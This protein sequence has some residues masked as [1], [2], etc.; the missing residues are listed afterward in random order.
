MDAHPARQG[1]AD[2]ALTLISALMCRAK[3]RYPLLSGSAPMK[4]RS[5]TVTLPANPMPRLCRPAAPAPYS[6]SARLPPR[7]SNA[8]CSVMPPLKPQRC[9]SGAGK[10]CATATRPAGPSTASSRWL[11]P[12]RRAQLPA[13]EP[14]GCLWHKHAAGCVNRWARARGPGSR[15]RCLLSSTNLRHAAFRRLKWPAERSRPARGRSRSLRLRPAMAVPVHVVVEV[16]VVD[17]VLA[18]QHEHVRAALLQAPATLLFLILSRGASRGCRHLSAPPQETRRAGAA[19]KAKGQVQALRTS[20]ASSAGRTP[21]A[22][23][24]PPAPCSCR[25]SRS[26]CSMLPSSSS[27]FPL[28]STVSCTPA[29][30]KHPTAM[31]TTVQA[32]TAVFAMKC[33]GGAS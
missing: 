30:R 29:R 8:R 22:L 24:R 27:A 28:H 23:T 15:S 3:Q 19:H 14:P 31:A 11:A 12:E 25:L 7:S 33:A 26:P 1:K 13:Q 20:V 4:H 16:D 6:S 5:S 18:Q 10:L 32:G 9:A 2:R 21:S 17:R